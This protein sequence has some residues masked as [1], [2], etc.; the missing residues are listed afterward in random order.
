M[1]KVLDAL[2][3]ETVLDTAKRLSALEAKLGVMEESIEKLTNKLTPVVDKMTRWE[4]KFGMLF[5]VVGCVW[6]FFLAS[7]KFII[8]KLGA[9]FT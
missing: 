6:T 7:W 4:A 3:A 9:L 2:L 5:F 1:E 8:E